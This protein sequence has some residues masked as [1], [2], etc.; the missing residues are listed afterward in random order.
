MRRGAPGGGSQECAMNEVVVVVGG[1][2][3]T[4]FD[5]FFLFCYRRKNLYFLRVVKLLFGRVE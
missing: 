3:N 1:L 4:E 5:C 2:R